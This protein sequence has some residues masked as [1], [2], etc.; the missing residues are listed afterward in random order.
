M[1]RIAIV[2]GSGVYDFPAENKREET[3]KTPYGEVKITV[4]VVGDEEVA[5][6][7]RHGK[8][9]SIPPHKINYRANIWALYELGVERIIATSA[10]GSMNPEMKP[11]DFVILDQIIDFTVSRP[12]TFYDGEE[13]PHERK[14]VAHVDFTEPYCPEIRKALITAARNLGLPYH[15]RGTYVCTEG[16]R[17]ETAAEI[18][19]Y[20]ILG[21]DVVGM[22]QC[23]EAILARELEMC[24]ATVAI[25]TNYAAGMSGKKLTHSEVVELMQK[26]SE[27]IVKLILAAIPLI[28][29]ERRCGCKDALKGATG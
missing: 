15:P 8:G 21:G 28:P 11:G 22:T 1:P 25:V 2:G 19:A 24:Y 16:P 29:K 14:F 13:S 6:L 10:V 4:G 23:P 20:R 27:D 5:F 3:V 26:K 7:A 9:H 12:R 17:F 18:R